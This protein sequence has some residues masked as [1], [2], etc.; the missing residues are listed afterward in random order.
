M[1]TKNRRR[2]KKQHSRRQ[3]K[4][5]KTGAVVVAAP[6]RL[7]ID[8]ASVSSGW[9]LFKG[10]ALCASGT[11]LADK[12]LNVVA[13]LQQVWSEYRHIFKALAIDEVHIEM[14]PRRVH[15]YTIWSV[16]VIA[17]AL[18]PYVATD[19]IKDDVPVR[20][21]QKHCDWNSIETEWKERGYTSED[22]MAAIEM[23][24]WYLET[25]VGGLT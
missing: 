24:R 25:K 17:L 2:L 1:P 23:G 22:E 12:K 8:P 6:V 21:W 7:F 5:S 11:V 20:S 19:K 9:A 15:H 14:M 16:G 4:V 18:Y 13:R 3:R 10:K